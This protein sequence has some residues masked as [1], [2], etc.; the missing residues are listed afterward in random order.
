[1]TELVVDP[2]VIAVCVS[3][4]FLH[5]L[6]RMFPKLQGLFFL[7]PGST[8]T[9]PFQVVTAGFLEDSTM[10]LLLCI[11]VLIVC[12]I[13]LQSTWG[14]K[15]LARF[16]LLTNIAQACVSWVGMIVLYILFRSEHFL[17]VRF[18]CTARPATVRTPP[19]GHHTKPTTSSDQAV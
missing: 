9:Q 12:S 17:F 1:M 14:A 3:M 15:E 5:L 16:V 18:P 7:I 10:N 4:A 8:I 2:L 13:L 6:I 19:L 11:A